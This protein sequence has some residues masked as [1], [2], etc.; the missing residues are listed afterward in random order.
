MARYLTTIDST[1]PPETAFA[2]LADFASAER[3]DPGV[4]EARRLDTGALGVGSRFHLVTRFA[5]RA[6]PLEYEIVEFD[7]PNR[8]M[9]RA[10]NAT[11][12]SVDSITFEPSAA[13]TTVTYDANLGLKGPLRIFD[14]LLAIVFRRIGDRARDGLRTALRPAAIESA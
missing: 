8:V 3:W 1:L 6:V 13:G 7:P 10:G 14:S 11:V 9:L 4:V 5:G 12:V 2:E